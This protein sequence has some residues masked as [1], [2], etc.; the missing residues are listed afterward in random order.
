MTVAVRPESAEVPASYA[1][2]VGKVR[3]GEDLM[4]LMEGQLE[5]VRAALR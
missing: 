4:G 5:E 1:G 3:D 2:Y